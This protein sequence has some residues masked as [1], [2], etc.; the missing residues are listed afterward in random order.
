VHDALGAAEFAGLVTVDSPERFSFSHERVREVLVDQLTAEEE[1]AAHARA[2]AVVSRSGAGDP[3]RE[4]RGAHHALR[5]ATRSAADARRAVDACR[6]AAEAM[7]AGF[8]YEE[9]ESLLASAVAA[10]E[11]AGL[12]D[13]AAPLVVEWAEAVLRCGRLAEARALFDRAAALAMAEDDPIMLARAAVGLGGVWINEHRTTLDWERVTGLQRRALAGLPAYQVA[14]RHRLIVRLAAEEVYRGGPVEPVLVAMED[15]R[16]LGDGRVLAEALSL[17][18]HALLT[19]RHTRIRLALAEELIAVAS[20]AGEGMLALIGLCWRAVDLFHLSDPRATRALAELRERADAL[21]CL[22]VLYIA[23]SMEV[24]LL[25]RAGRLDEAEAKAHDCFALGSRIGDADALGYLGAHLTTIRWLQDR[26]A[27]MLATIEQIA[28]SPSLN[29]ADFAF[30]ATVASLAARTGRPEL[31]QTVLARLTTAGLAALPESSTWL[32]GMLAIVEAARVL[33]DARLAAQAYDLLAPYAELPVMPSL[34]VTCLGSVHR[35]LGL[36]ALTCGDVPRAAEH[37][38]EAVRAT[39]LL[40]NRPVTAVTMAELAEA[41]L[42]RQRPDDRR[43]AADLLDQARAEADAMGMP[44]RGA[45][46]QR[47]LA[48]IATRDATITHQGRH[49]T[50]TVGERRTVVPD[51]L[52]VRYLARLLTNPGR[53]IAAL[54]LAGGPAGPALVAPGGQPVL[55]RHARAAY[56]R[57]ITELTNQLAGTG[58]RGGAAVDRRLRTELDA[59]LG[60]L[61]QVT[62]RAGRTRH[63]PDPAER[64]RTAVRKAIKRAVDAVAAADPGLGAVLAATV[65]TGASCCYSPDPGAPLHWTYTDERRP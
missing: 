11:R 53:P 25:I 57:R 38:E 32:A 13:P 37:L 62:G 49:W 15:A 9:A 58:D 18:H 45:A 8:A 20:P 17:G 51:R 63:F 36:A 29:P 46:W 3:D 52:G 2:A 6:V 7:T 34:A 23:E 24:M 16:A 31:A 30:E 64:A 60:E 14:L 48:E 55:D 56:R 42:R 35:A 61:R 22:S 28:D 54:D 12:A 39:R 65:S 59:L 33:G 50:L 41:L 44:A 1:L 5:A 10:H 4:A 26:D 19:P 21:G 47:R 43:R 27:E 40:G